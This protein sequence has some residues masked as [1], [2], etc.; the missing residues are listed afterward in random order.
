MPTLY[1]SPSSSSLLRTLIPSPLSEP[2][3]T[4]LYRTFSRTRS[5]ATLA[6]S[7]Q[8]SSSDSQP[9][10]PLSQPSIGGAPSMLPT[11]A[12]PPSAISL[13]QTLNTKDAASLSLLPQSALPLPQSML[14][15]HYKHYKGIFDAILRGS[16]DFSLECLNHSHHEDPL[17][18]ADQHAAVAVESPNT[19][20]LTVLDEILNIFQNP[21]SIFACGSN[22]N[23]HN[24]RESMMNQMM[25]SDINSRIGSCMPLSS[26]RIGTIIHNIELNSGQGG[27]L[28]RAAGTC[29]KILKEP[30][31]KY[32][33][34]QLTMDSLQINI[35]S[36]V[37]SDPCS[38]S[39]Q[40]ITCKNSCCFHGSLEDMAIRFEGYNFTR[41]RSLGRKKVVS[42]NV[43]GSPLDSETDMALLKRVCSGRFNFNS[44]RS[45]LEALPLDILIRVLC[46]VNHE[47]LEQLLH[48]SKTISEAAEVAK[49]FHFEYSTPKKKT[50]DSFHTFEYSTWSG[51]KSDEKTTYSIGT[52]LKAFSD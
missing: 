46:G 1:P 20:L 25:Y 52:R 28:V 49:R 26:M 44:E 47:D 2:S 34:I 48:V 21:A 36:W 32:C 15:P 37:G 35:P 4:A 41:T 10:H 29:A 19:R 7:M 9:S 12:C 22:T 33:L 17:L 14:N 3:F 23:A 42:G 6:P 13:S 11:S 39:W 30:T 45:L 50:F 5:V 38:G 16:I 18:L 51:P 40:G 27:K 24:A 43:K 31:S 8:A